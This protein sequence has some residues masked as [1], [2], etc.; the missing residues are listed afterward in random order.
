MEER[1]ESPK[2]SEPYP[3]IRHCFPIACHGLLPLTYFHTNE[4]NNWP[5]TLSTWMTHLLSL[6]GNLQLCRNEWR[7]AAREGK[8]GCVCHCH[9]AKEKGPADI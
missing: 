3:G 6:F 8:V 1:C 5:P 7:R 2:D 4:V 9:Y